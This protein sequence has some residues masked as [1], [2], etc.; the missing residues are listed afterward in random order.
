MGSKRSKPARGNGTGSGKCIA[1]AA[2]GPENSAE[3]LFSQ[4]QIATRWLARRAGLSLVMAA[5]VA[6]ANAFGG[7]TR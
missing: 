5:A 1:V 6:S 7:T 4:E 3:A 2:C